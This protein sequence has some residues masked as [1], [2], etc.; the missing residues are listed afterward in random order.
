MSLK[1]Y[2]FM[3][4]KHQLDA[5]K[6]W[7]IDSTCFEHYYAHL[8]EYISKYRFL[9]SKHVESKNQHFVASS[10]SLSYTISMMHGHT[11]IKF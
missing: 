9:V 4:D 11:N 2:D 6:C 1:H 5:T 3:Y 10:W 8:Q 7:F